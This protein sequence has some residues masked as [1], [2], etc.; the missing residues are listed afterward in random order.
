ML[1]LNVVQETRNTR[2]IHKEG[3]R[4]GAEGAQRGRRGSKSAEGGVRNGRRRADAHSKIA[5]GLKPEAVAKRGV[6]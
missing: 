6:C 2:H 5:Q 3:C 1:S 4:G